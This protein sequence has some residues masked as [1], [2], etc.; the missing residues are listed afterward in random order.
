MGSGARKRVLWVEIPK[1]L[2]DQ[3]IREIVPNLEMGLV[4]LGFQKYKILKKGETGIIASSPKE[5]DY[6]P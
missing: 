1:E 4:K 3:T 6:K 2:P 5:G